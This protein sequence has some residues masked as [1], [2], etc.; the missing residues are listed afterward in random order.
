MVC[1]AQPGLAGHVAGG[2]AARARD[3]A[4]PAHPATAAPLQLLRSQ[5]APP[6]KDGLLA[7]RQRAA[8]TKPERAVVCARC[9]HEVTADG[10]RIPVAGAHEHRFVNPHGF[11]FDVQ[12]FRAAPGCDVAGPPTSDFSWFPGFAWSIAYCGGCA[13]HLGWRFEGHGSEFFALIKDRL[14]CADG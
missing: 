12:C 10:A 2:G 14:A 3:G 6:A 11:V 1:G 7:K 13:A 8:G 4:P 9:R 5:G